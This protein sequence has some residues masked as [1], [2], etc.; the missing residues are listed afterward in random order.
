MKWLY[1]NGR[2][3]NVTATLALI[4]AMSGTSVA[5]ITLAKNSVGGPQLKA[6][7]VTSGK[8]K[9]GTL[10]KADFKPGQL[11]AGARGATGAPGA[12]GPAGPAGATGPAGS[13]PTVLASGQTLQG[14]VGPFGLAASGG[15]IAVANVSFPFPLA[16]APTTHFIIFGTGNPVGCTGTPTNPAASPGHLC[17]YETTAAVNATSNRGITG[18]LGDNT[19]SRFGFSGWVT[20]AAG[21]IFGYYGTWAVTA[22]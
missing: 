14:Y 15:Q 21:G 8:V 18:P 19:A 6:N 16:S 13:L 5:A 20:A 11:L 1:G 4:A 3:A 17:V 9:N 22:A 10:L 7:S 2:Y 12:T